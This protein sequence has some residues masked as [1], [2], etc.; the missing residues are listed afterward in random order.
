MLDEAERVLEL[1]PRRNAKGVRPVQV[2]H[3]HAR[4]VQRAI[5]RADRRVDAQRVALHEHAVVA[6][7]ADRRRRGVEH[8]AGR[9][10]R[11]VGS[12]ARHVPLVLPRACAADERHVENARRGRSLRL[13][14]GD[15]LVEAILGGLERVVS[16][17][18]ARV[19]EIGSVDRREHRRAEAFAEQ[20]DAPRFVGGGG[21]DEYLPVVARRDVGV[22]PTFEERSDVVGRHAGGLQ[23]RI[24]AEAFAPVDGV[25]ALIRLH[26]APVVG[27][28]RR[29]LC[30]IVELFAFET[31]D[32]DVR[33]VG[34]LEVGDSAVDEKG[35]VGRRLEG[36]GRDA[37]WRVHRQRLVHVAAGEDES[38]RR[39]RNERGGP[40]A[41]R[42]QII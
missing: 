6:A 2:L 28:P 39:R 42:T 15:R 1:R 3:R 14:H 16:R 22:G 25:H 13:C 5:P 31:A 12:R 21:G 9:N 32:D 17:G 24:D 19:R 33:A 36:P 41:P 23:R 26:V 11:G 37:A 29:G 38:H 8:E 35:R 10:E 34:A 4:I 27:P 30:V 18:L 7:A 40:P 20:Q